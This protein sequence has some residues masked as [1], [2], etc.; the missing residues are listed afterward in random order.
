[1]IENRP[2]AGGA[3]ATEAVS[4]AVPDGSTLFITAPQFLIN[5]HLR[6][7]NYEPLTSFRPIC[8]LVR[9]PTVIVVNS[10]SPYRTLADLFN[11]A[12]SKPGDLTLA[13][14]GPAT[15]TQIAFEMV[16]RAA[17]VDMNFVPYPGMAPVINALLGG[18]VTSAFGNYGDIFEQLSAGNLR[19]LA[20]GSGMRI[21]SLP[22]VPTL[23]ESGYGDYVADVWYGLVAPRKTP[24]DKL[25]RLIG[26]F[27]AAMQAPALKLKLAAQGLYP[28]GICGKD[29]VAII[30][31]QYDE[32]GRVIREAD[33]KAE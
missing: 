10:A 9:S 6:K 8:Y 30:R 15:V 1:V 2:G 26:W 3:I 33:I 28:V 32:Y 21:E 24:K 25:S 14:T 31:K 27:G 17:N 20:T 16:K 5:A 29:Y 13:S 22:E 23:A 12:R 11:A 7:L 18:H 19:A 4:R